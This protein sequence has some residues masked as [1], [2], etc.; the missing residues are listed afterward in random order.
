MSIDKR[1]YKLVRYLLFLGSGQ[2]DP[3]LSNFLLRIS[4]CGYDYSRRSEK[5]G[6]FERLGLSKSKISHMQRKRRRIN[7]QHTQASK[8]CCHFKRC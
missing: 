2:V 6:S 5:N 4:D 3:S 1:G 8:M 7:T